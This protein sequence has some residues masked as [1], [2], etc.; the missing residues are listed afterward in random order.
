MGHDGR[1]KATCDN[2][3]A[4]DLPDLRKKADAVTSLTFAFS[5]MQLLDFILD[6]SLVKRTVGC[7]RGLNLTRVNISEVSGDGLEPR[8]GDSNHDALD[9]VKAPFW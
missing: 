9:A 5:A 4:S 3:H 2:H 6:V 8:S 1:K 7:P